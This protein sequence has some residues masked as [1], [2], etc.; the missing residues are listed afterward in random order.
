M[1][2][3]SNIVKY[4]LERFIIQDLFHSKM[5]Y[6]LSMENNVKLQFAR[7]FKRYDKQTKITKYLCFQNAFITIY[8]LTESINGEST[9]S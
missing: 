5:T 6:G 3:S 2:D 7:L 8:F 1:L 9:N 4:K